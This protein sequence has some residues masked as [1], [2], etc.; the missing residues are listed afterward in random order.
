MSTAKAEIFQLS[1]KCAWT[2][3]Q[4]YS[5][6]SYGR[7]FT[8]VHVNVEW[9]W[10]LRLRLILYNWFPVEEQL[11]PKYWYDPGGGYLLDF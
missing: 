9:H 10:T 11:L 1:Y 5:V 6:S 4:S 3:P 2:G 7:L 8:Q